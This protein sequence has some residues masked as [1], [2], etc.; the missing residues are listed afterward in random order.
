MM[1][2][3]KAGGASTL[4]RV[5]KRVENLTKLG[6]TS[7]ASA[8]ETTHS[9]SPEETLAFADWINVS[10]G[11]DADCKGKLPIN[12][13]NSA[14]GLFAAVKDGVILCKLVNAAVAGT[15][16]DRAINK[17]KL[18]Q[19]TMSENCTLALGSAAAIG[20][21]VVNIGPAD[22][23]AG[24]AHL[25]LGVLWQVIRVG[26]FAGINLSSC[27][28]LTRLLEGDETLA[29]LM[30][31][32]PDQLL[33]RW[34]NYHLKAAGAARRIR[35]FTTDIKD[36]EAYIYLL[37]QIAPPA[38]NVGTGALGL[39]DP[40]VRTARHWPFT[41]IFILPGPPSH[42]RPTQQRA[43]RMLADAERMDARKFVRAADVLA[44][45]AKL[46]LAFV[47]HLFNTYP[48]LAPQDLA[49]A[50]FDLGQTQETREER[51][52]RCWMNSLGVSPFVNS[53]YG[54]L[55]DGLVLLQLLELIRPGIV[56]KAKVNQPPF[57]AI[58]ANMKKVENLNYVI[59]L[60]KTL[61][62]SMVGIG[63]KD[64]YDGV[65]GLTL[66]VVWQ[67]MRA[68]T[69]NL[70]QSLSHGGQSKITDAQIVAFVNDTLKQA[71]KPGITGF[72]D[73][74]IGTS[75]PVL[76]L[77]NAIKPDA[78]QEALIVRNP[79]TDEQKM[80]N[81]KLAI[82]MSRKIGARVYALPEDLAE[83]QPKMCMTVFAC[84]YARALGG[85]K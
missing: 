19:F 61:Q 80:A 58:G 3:V 79:E 48:G 28:G 17:G 23:M 51:T 72:K 60:C 70:L 52:F 4:A 67:L 47:A 32:P 34:V 1:K 21:N 54:D 5:V 68:Y 42:P 85:R 10:L 55:Q 27:P 11:K 76:D 46:N 12:L 31:L 7:E 59:D 2:K 29:D 74:A 35:N 53:L 37:A 15:I 69:L 56:D 16:D 41:F 62:F 81:A 82:S 20:C 64:I 43:E 45:N 57:K 84:L 8:A 33:L 73:P 18:N 26:L 83:V 78:V 39:T 25:V 49:L 75:L 24:T 13:E 65:K 66:A 9:F 22:I 30:R 6:G 50:D 71:G 40:A 63:G 36:S 14:S 38:F 77:V 44:G